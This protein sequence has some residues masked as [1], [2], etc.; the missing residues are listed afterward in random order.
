MLTILAPLLLTA[1]PYFQVDKGRVD[2]FPLEETRTS[3]TIAGVIARVRVTQLYKNEGAAPIEAT[4]VFPAGPRAAV[5]GLEMR[6]GGRTLTAKIAERGEARA[7]YEKARDEG[8]TAG[9]LEQDRP[10]VLAMNVTNILPGD[11]VEVVLDY[12][13]L[14]APQN[15]VYEWVHPTVV[16][17]RYDPSSKNIANKAPRTGEPAYRWGLSGKITGG[18]PIAALESPSHVLSPRSL[19]GGVAFEISDDKG[20]NRDFVLR[21]RLAGDKIQTGLLLYPGEEYGHFLLMVQPPKKPEPKSF[22][23][24]EYIFVLD[25]SGSM[26]GFPL[27]IAKELMRNLLGNLRPMDRFNVLLFSGGT[28]LLS[29]TSLPAT[30]E[31]LER[32]RDLIDLQNGGGGTEILGALKR[33]LEL[34]RNQD[35]STSIVVVTDGYV[36]IEKEVF[37]YVAKNLGSAN[38]FSFGIGTAVNRFLI[39]GLARAG[40]GEPF[41]ILHPSEAKEVAEKFRNYVE[42]PVLTN[43]EVAMNGFDAFDIEPPSLP[44]VFADRP[45]IV[46]GKYRGTPKRTITVKGQNS[47]GPQTMT[48]DP[49]TAVA[50][51]DLIALKYLWARH[52]IERLE[53]QRALEETKTIKKEILQLGLDHHLLT[54]Q[55][56]FVAIDSLKRNH[57]DKPIAIDQPVPLPEGVSHNAIGSLGVLGVIGHGAGG[58]GSALQGSGALGQPQFLPSNPTGRVANGQA[59]VMGSLDRSVIQRVIQQN[60]ARIRYAY[61]REL[62]KNPNLAG[63][64]VVKFTVGPE[65]KVTAAQIASSTVND[66]VV[67]EQVLRVIRSLQF[68]KIPGGGSLQVTY[69]FIF[70]TTP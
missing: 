5:Y 50:S 3:V 55:T 19:A 47:E 17:P 7:D 44:D 53:D 18:V 16:G 43:V 36:T 57:G 60:K 67:E 8:K 54:S 29:E 65:G 28:G 27:D 20:G 33:A 32:A 69:P 2:R 49:A 56:S 41:V 48:V 68:P 13:E 23:P 12:T 15:G 52:K 1:A 70:S 40:M 31:N 4:Y 45:V 21:Y 39:D 59:L 30:P 24:R 6:I 62:T 38:L 10:N 42:S 22:P 66:A 14:I 58:G 25:V 26:G 34:P 9:L 37:E 63:K 11:R 35:V 64:I 46:F 51:D 61:E